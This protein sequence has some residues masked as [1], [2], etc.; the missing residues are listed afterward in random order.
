[1]RLP[2]FLRRFWSI[3]T[4][5]SSFLSVGFLTLGGFVGGVLFWGGFNTALEATNT[6]AFCTSCHEMQ[7]NVFE[8]LT[9]TVHYTNRSGVRA[10]C[11]DCHVPHEWTDKIARKMQASKEVW[12]HLFGTIDTRRKFLDNRLRLAE[13]E[14]A[15]LKAND[16]LECRNCH[17]EVAMDFTRQT[18]RAAQIHTQYLIQTEGYTCIDCH[19]GIAHEL[20]DMRGIDPGWLPPADLRASLP[21]H[22]SSFDL[23][24]ARAYVAD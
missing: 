8:E 12:G 10:G 1:M 6:E 11:P 15:R 14:W 7:S 18:D 21:D 5:P 13:H 16:S 20:P 24:G 19:K 4:S 3:A 22:G 2:S 23:E 17:S 9:R